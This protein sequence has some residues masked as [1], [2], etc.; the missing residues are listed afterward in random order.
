MQL[1]QFQIVTQK[2]N[3][4]EKLNDQ[5]FTILSFLQGWLYTNGGCGP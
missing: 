2:P 3:E 4:L 1:F 5:E